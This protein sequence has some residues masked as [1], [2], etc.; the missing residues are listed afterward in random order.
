MPLG[1]PQWFL[2]SDPASAVEG[3]LQNRGRPA[4]RKKARKSRLTRKTGAT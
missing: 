1:S 2:R 3:A 4:A